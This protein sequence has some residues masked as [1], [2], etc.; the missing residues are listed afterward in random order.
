MMKCTRLQKRIQYIFELNIRL[1][2]WDEN[3]TDN[4]YTDIV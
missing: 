2:F 3:N 1:D 4:V